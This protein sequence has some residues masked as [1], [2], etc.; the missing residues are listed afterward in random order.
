MKE[1]N[2]DVVLEE[3]PKEVIERVF[4]D[5]IR[6]SSRGLLKA[7]INSYSGH[8]TSYETTTDNFSM[9][10][11]LG[12]KKTVYHNI[13]NELGELDKRYYTYEL[14]IESVILKNYKYRVLFFRYGEAGY[15]VTV[16]VADAISRQLEIDCKGEKPYI[17]TINKHQEL[18]TLANAILCTKAIETTMQEA[19]TASLLKK[20]QTELDDNK[21]N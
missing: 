10:A 3:L 13:Q 20:K 15:P 19:I 6:E 12:E 21:D 7:S 11:S 14:I 18:E 5:T 4:I 2:F 17:Y 9:F 1:F 8:I 16:V